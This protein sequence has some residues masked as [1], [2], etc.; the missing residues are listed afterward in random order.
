MAVKTAGTEDQVGRIHKMATT[1]YEMKLEAILKSMKASPEDAEYLGDLKA[2]QAASKWV[3]YNEVK[4][5]QAVDEE[6]NPLAKTLA[7]VK[8]FTIKAVAP[9]LTKEA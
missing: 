8:S 5:L 9:T 7:E 1:I 4:S 2:I 6:D 3:E